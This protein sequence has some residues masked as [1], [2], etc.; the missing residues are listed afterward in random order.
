MNW[1]KL[2]AGTEFNYTHSFYTVSNLRGGFATQPI[3]PGA[4]TATVLPPPDFFTEP[5]TMSMNETNKVP[6]KNE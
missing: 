5:Q 1:E 4:P 3:V 2:P 6:D